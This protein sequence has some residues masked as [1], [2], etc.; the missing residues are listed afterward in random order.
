MRSAAITRPHID[1]EIARRS[2][3]A[4]VVSLLL[5][6]V[7]V[8]VLDWGTRPHDAQIVARDRG[9]AL[10][11]RLIEPGIETPPLEVPVSPPPPVTRHDAPRSR[12]RRV[13]EPRVPAPPPHADERTQEGAAATELRLFDANGRVHLPGSAPGDLS[14]VPPFPL[15]PLAVHDGDPFA[16]RNPV[17]YEPTRFESVWAPRDETLGGELLRKITLERTFLTPWGTQITCAWLL[18]LGGCSWGYA[19]TA[20]IEELQQMRADPPMLKHPYVEPVPAP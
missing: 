17:P 5:N 11:V 14:A 19:P 8:I 12:T 2:R 13:P 1:A 16:R 10:Q 18:V 9:D 6:I 15:S 20:T 7:F 4:L 3:I